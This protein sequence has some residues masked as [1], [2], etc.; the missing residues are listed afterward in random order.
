LSDPFAACE[1][2]VRRYD[3]DR[4][5]AALFAPEKKRRHLFALTAF[6]RELAHAAQAAREPMIVDIRLAWWREALE[7]ARAGRPRDHH[8]AQALCGMFA[9]IDLP[10]DMFARMIEARAAEVGAE[11]F[12]DA[13]AAEEHA[14]ATS[15]TLMRLAARVLGVEADDL[16]REAGIAYSLAGR[17]G[18]KFSNIDCATLAREH[19]V[20]ARAMPMPRQALPAFFPAALVPLDLKRGEPP[21]WRKQIVYL[22]ASWRGRI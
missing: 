10:A 22:R 12:A 6:Y 2:E 15:G 17:S 20:V 13:A 14:D 9:A 3:P 19:F 8:V 21:L 16:A 1:E 11:P 7:G 18:G 4:Y 5:F